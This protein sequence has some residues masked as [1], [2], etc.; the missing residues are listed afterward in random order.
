MRAIIRIGVVAIIL[1]SIIGIVKF[2]SG[3]DMTLTRKT[4]TQ[5]EIDG[6]VEAIKNGAAGVKEDFDHFIN[7]TGD[8]INYMKTGDSK[9]ANGLDDLRG[10]SSSDTSAITDEGK[11][12]GGVLIKDGDNYAVYEEAAES[13]EKAAEKRDEVTL[14]RVIDGDTLLVNHD[15]EEERIRLIGIDTPESVNPDKEKNNE[16]GEAASSFTKGLLSK[17]DTLYLEYDAERTDK[18][19]RTLAY[20]W[21]DKTNTNVAYM[22]NAQII[23]SGY[24]DTIIIEPNTKYAEIF[25]TMRDQAKSAGSGLWGD[26]GYR[27]LVGE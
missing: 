16:Y 8:F 2:A 26:K 18:Y 27:E 5:I 1:L 19:D 10:G 15:G 3:S 12:S 25:K 23:R 6:H 11:D 21:R 7:M 24:A 20:V 17:G 22:V 14:I 4:G 9:Y 13:K